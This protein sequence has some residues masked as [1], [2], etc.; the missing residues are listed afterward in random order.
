MNVGRCYSFLSATT[1][2]INYLYKALHEHEGNIDAR[3]DLHLIEEDKEDEGISVLSPPDSSQVYWSLC[4]GIN[5]YSQKRSKVA[6]AKRLLQ[7]KEKEREEKR[8]AA[9]STGAEWHSDNSDDESP[10]SSPDFLIWQ[11]KTS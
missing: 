7:K 9:L 8:A 5:Y 2:A 10:V 6:R 4:W 1:Q 11:D 3:L